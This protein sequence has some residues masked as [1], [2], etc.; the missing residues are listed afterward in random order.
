MSKKI[1]V[2]YITTKKYGLQYKSGYAIITYAILYWVKIILEN[3]VG[4][5]FHD[6]IKLDTRRNNWVV[7]IKLIF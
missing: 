5:T 4:Y 3:R 6:L 7:I 2:M 1:I